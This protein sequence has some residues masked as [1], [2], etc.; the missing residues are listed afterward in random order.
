MSRVQ[1]LSVTTIKGLYG[2]ADRQ[3]DSYNRVV[4]LHRVMIDFCF[5]IDLNYHHL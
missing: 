3:Q 4:R 2:L 1:Y 5:L